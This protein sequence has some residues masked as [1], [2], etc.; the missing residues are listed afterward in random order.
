MAA[1]L[2]VS[3]VFVINFY[4]SLSERY[5]K[6]DVSDNILGD[7]PVDQFPVTINIIK[8]EGLLKMV[9]PG[10]GINEY[11]LPVTNTQFTTIDKMMV[12]DFNEEDGKIV[13]LEFDVKS[14]G[15]KI[16]AKKQ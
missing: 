6:F 13:G 4:P 8:E 3:H 11:L 5:K 7:Y 14:Q 12:L 1:Q 16:T 9:I 2:S 10:A 15:L